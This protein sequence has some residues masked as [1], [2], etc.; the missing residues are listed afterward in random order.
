MAEND[1]IEQEKSVGSDYQRYLEFDLGE[2][3]YAVHLLQVKEVIPVPD[4]TPI[5]NSLNYFKGIMNIR[6][7]VISIIDL[8]IKLGI[9]PKEDQSNEAVI[10]VDI[11]GMQIGVIVDSI[12]KVLIVDSASVSKVPE[13]KT[14]INAKYIQG[15][16]RKGD[17]LTSILDMSNVLDV[18][19]LHEI[20]QHLA[21]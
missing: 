1:I 13:V 19:D 20:K 5:P 6:G 14:Q 12:N 8:R 17:S 7:H 4:S 3:H 21:A 9:R 15:I 2:E 10:I 18:N 16:H 11:N